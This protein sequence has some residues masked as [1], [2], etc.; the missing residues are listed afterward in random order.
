MGTVRNTTG[1]VVLLA[2]VQACTDPAKAPAE[3]AMAAAG[4]AMDSLKG[5]AVRYAPDA[6]KRLESS[7]QTVKDA[8]ANKDYKEAL[9]FARDIPAKASDLLASVD[10]TK[11]ALAQAWTEAGEGMTRTL[12]AARKRLDAL[13]REKR[14]PAGIDRATFSRADAELASIAA[15]WAAATDQYGSGDRSG[16][17]AKAKELIG[18]GQELLGTLGVK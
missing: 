11:A 9:L 17:V 13:S 12:D 7:Y 3:A 18:R 14:L 5:D 2:L 1:M 15:G 10:R 4:P 8:M 16:A 6:V